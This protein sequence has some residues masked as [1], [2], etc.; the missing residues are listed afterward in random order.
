MYILSVD[1]MSYK[2]NARYEKI[3]KLPLNV[4]NLANTQYN[5]KHGLNDY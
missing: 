3:I 5:N 1:S 2:C 4:N